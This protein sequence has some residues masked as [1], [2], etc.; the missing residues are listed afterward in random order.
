MSFSFWV[1]LF[2]FVVA[3]LM[4]IATLAPAFG[5]SLRKASRF[6]SEI[7]STGHRGAA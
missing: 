1:G 2:W 4:A 7:T 6:S 5:W 3:T